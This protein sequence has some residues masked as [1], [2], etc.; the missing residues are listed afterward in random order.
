MKKI[1]LTKGLKLKTL[2]PVKIID[3]CYNEPSV[4][5]LSVHTVVQVTGGPTR[6]SDVPF[7][8]LK[9]TGTINR[10]MK[11]YRGWPIEKIQDI[12]PEKNSHGF[13]FSQGHETHAPY[14]FGTLSTEYFE[15]INES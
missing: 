12:T 3:N 6:L 7:K 5:T 11:D 10:R 9:G 15:V 2:K 13:F 8:V 14:D 1:R 4:G